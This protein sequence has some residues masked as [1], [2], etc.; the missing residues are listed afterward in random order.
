MNRYSNT[1]PKLD[2]SGK[3][4]YSTTYYPEIPLSNSDNFTTVR[5]GARLDILASNHYG[6]SSLWWVIAK[7]NGIKGINVLNAGQILRIPGNITSIIE[8]FR[9]LN[10][11]D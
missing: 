8:K 7:A 11:I 6:D 5:D 3:K 4:V 1:Q 10:N 9:Q 2:K